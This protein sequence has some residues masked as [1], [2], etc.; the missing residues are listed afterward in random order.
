LN[1]I[2]FPILTPIQN[3]LNL[4]RE[5]AILILK[6]IV[7]FVFP[8]FI[9]LSIFAE[10]IFKIL[11]TEKWVGSV[12][13]FQLL[14]FSALLYPVHVFNLTV[15]NIKGKS[16]KVLFLQIIKT[17]I[18][19]TLILIFIGVGVIG[20]MYGLVIESFLAFFLNSFFLKK[21]INF[22]P[23][24]QLKEM[25]PIILL[26]LVYGIFTM[27]LNQILI[28]QNFYDIVRISICGL[29]SSSFYYL[30]SK[31]FFKQILYNIKKIIIN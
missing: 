10:P 5:K 17:L 26:S 9:F 1:K 25:L 24:D 22:G 30:L 12:K 18:A 6:I 20:L 7:F 3:D 4:F 31:I 16:D 11:F 13:Y 8:F 19:V 28:N 23:I 21:I 15:L 14:C 2:L 29:I 27:Y